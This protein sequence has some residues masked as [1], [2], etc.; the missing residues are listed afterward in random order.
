M[1]LQQSKRFQ[2]NYLLLSFLLPLAGLLLLRL[3]CTLTFDGKYSMLHSDC[4]HQY[5]PFFKAFRKA[6]LS[7]QSLLFT[8]DVGMGTDYLGLISY[9]LASPLNLLSVLVP[10]G[11][12]LGYFSLLMPVKLSLASL[13]FA[14]FL[15]NVFHKDDFSLCLFGAFYALCAWSLGYQ[16]NIMWLD[17]FALLPLVILGMHCLL[18]QRKFVLYTLALFI[19]V[20][21]SYYI[22][23]FV[24]IFVLLSFICYEICRWTNIRRFFADLMYMALFSTLAIGMT[25]VLSIPALSALQSTQ[26]SVNTFPEGFKL[27]IA[28]ENTWLGLIDAMRQVAGQM[29]GGLVPTFKEGL[30]NL[31]CGVG[32]SV[33]AL[34]FLTCR[35]VK[36]RDKLCSVGLLLF[37]N[38]SFVVR[39]LDFIWHGFHFPNMIPYRF[40]FLYSFVVLYMAYRAWTLRKSFRP[41]QILTAAL[42]SLGLMACSDGMTPLVELI[43]GKKSLPSW[44]YN[45]LANLKTI[46]TACYFPLYNLL[47]LLGYLITLSYGLPGKPPRPQSK[48]RRPRRLKLAWLDT[49]H[50]KRTLCT[51][52][53]FCI[54]GFELVMVLYNFGVNYAGTDVSDYPRGTT[55][56]ASVVEYMHSANTGSDFYRAETTHSQSLNDGSLNGYY[57][58]SAFS[59][60]ANVQ[61]TKFMQSLG[62]GAKD[63][64]NR[65][66]FEESSPVANLFLNLKY[67]IDR[68]G[69]VVANSYFDDIYSSGSV[70]LLENNAYLPLGF[71]A[72]AQLMNTD[73]T[74]EGNRFVFQNDLIKDATGLTGDCF[75]MLSENCVT[76]YGSDLTLDSQQIGYCTYTADT[77]GTVTYRCTADR[78]G[79]FCF[80]VHQNKR[81][82]YSVYVN[83]QFVYSESYSLPQ[84]LSVCDVVPGDVVEIKFTCKSGESGTINVST[85]IVEESLFRQAYDILSAST[86]DLT[87]FETTRIEGTIHCNRDGVL[88]TSIPQDGNWVALVDGKD[89][90]IVKIG[91]AMIGLNLSEGVHTVQ[92]LYKNRAFSLGWKISLACLA[93]FLGL[94]WAIYRPSFSRKENKGKYQK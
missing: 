53:L 77:S 13:F 80:Y 3:V 94:T 58:V 90:Q 12:V 63:T 74:A 37:F 18:R 26:S 83:S 34:L 68:D 66:C 47:F 79:L 75:Q 38:I 61:V 62:Y 76:I 89:A 17:T 35:Q 42:L 43:C 60:S 93:V 16:W 67:M 21:S 41:W 55:D 44:E 11:W 5:F 48:N 72:N 20:W 33:L 39:Q 23:F 10:E 87:T 59:S 30:P 69:N 86:L 49:L 19:S 31:Y 91:N 85:A 32:S 56:A 9:Y 70:H 22:G 7:G 92:F 25:A 78:S 40:S 51:T 73:F 57:G 24:C 52:V 14:I 4:Y 36:L 1:K 28:D 82:S 71:L 65:Y 46:L 2:W 64:Y 81:N 45:T 50:K 88:Y 6:L 29:N 27:N 8:W 15:K 54:M 84:M